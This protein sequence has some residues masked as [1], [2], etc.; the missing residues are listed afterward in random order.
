LVILLKDNK[1]I[2]KIYNMKL[3]KEDA[4]VECIRL[5]RP[6]EAADKNW[7]IGMMERL[8]ERQLERA[9]QAPDTSQPAQEATVHERAGFN[10]YRYIAGMK[11]AP[12]LYHSAMVALAYLT[13]VDPRGERHSAREINEVLHAA[14]GRKVNIANM[15][16]MAA[17]HLFVDYSQLSKLRFDYWLTPKGIDEVKRLLEKIPM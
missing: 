9:L 15:M 14:I 2:R 13:D 10:R 16:G 6:L 11:V 8:T 4:L 12:T 5:I 17:S 3:T 7:V 1:S